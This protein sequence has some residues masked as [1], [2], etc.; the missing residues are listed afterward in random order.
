MQ[1]ILS[2]FLAVFFTVL[3]IGQVKH[4][5]SVTSN[6]FTPN[7]LTINAGD[8]VVWTNMGGTHNVNGTQGTYP[9]NPEDFGSG[10]ASSSAWTYSHVF[11]TAGNYEYRC[12]PHF[13]LGMEGTVTVN[14]NAL[15]LTA[16]Y[17][18][19]LPGGAPKG[20]E[21]FVMSDIDDLSAYGLGSANNGGGTDGQEFTFPAVSVT[22]GQFLH[23]TPDSMEFFNF[24]GSYPFALSGS[25]GVNGDDAIELFFNGEVVDI[26]G[27]INVDGSGTSWEYLDGWAYRIAGTGP[28]GSSFN[29]NNWSYSGANALD[30]E[31]SNSTAANPVPLS[32]YST[33]PP[34]SPTVS[35]ASASLNFSEEEGTIMVGVNIASPDGNPTSVDVALDGSTSTAINSADFTFVSPTTLTFP[36]GSSDPQ[37]FSINILD[38]GDTESDEDI[39][40]MLNNPTNNAQLGTSMLIIT[41]RDNDIVYTVETI[42]NVDDVDSNGLPVSDGSTV[43]LEGIVYGDNFRSSGLQFVIIDEADKNAGINIFN[44]SGNYGY[45]VKEGDKI[46]VQ[47]TVGHFRGLLQVS[48]DSV[49]LVSGDNALHDAEVVTALDE[50]TESKLVKLENVTLVN[51]SQWGNANSSFTVDVTDGTNTYEVRIDSDTDIDG[52]PMPTSSFNVTG[53]GWQS[54]GSSPHDSDYSLYPRRLSDFEFSTPPA[55]PSYP[56]YSISDIDGT[57]TNGLPDSLDVLCQLEGI[58]YGVNLRPSGL[59]FTLIDENDSDAGLGVFFSS[60]DLGYTVAEGDKVSVKGEIG[61][62]NG[63]LQLELDSIDFISSGNTL[64]EPEVVTTLDEVSESKLVRLIGVTFVDP[65]QWTGSGSGFNVEVTDGTNTFDI[66]IDADTDLYSMAAPSGSDVYT[67]TGLGGQFDNSDPRDEGYQLLPRSSADI[68][69]TT[70]TFE[71]RLSE[72]IEFYPNPVSKILYV[73]SS[74]LVDRIEVINLIGQV[75]QDFSVNARYK[76]LNVSKLRQGTYI[77]RFYSEDAFWTSKFIKK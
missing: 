68:W 44:S 65:S 72:D 77:V 58:V 40:L 71:P 5:V 64:H 38:D 33:M 39:V 6:V 41:I 18:G 50:S 23:I 19:P 45:T 29:S 31:S 20:V 30:G 24:F 1:K 13:S 27:D 7:N 17:D 36:A 62:F 74:V 11:N 53:L 69:N 51:P 32:T 12:D 42:D 28:D 55:G 56:S 49:W 63:F 14:D 47:G 48:A 61:H 43:E 70:S 66:R 16:V 21:V 73:E 25:M 26:F 2:T 54:D 9:S 34:S 76:E 37:M 67:I 22:A 3:A 4:D 60:G 57:D 75:V 35:F 46:K 8:T 15:L 52:T 59:Q 10:A